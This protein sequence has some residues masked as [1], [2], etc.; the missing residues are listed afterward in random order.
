MHARRCPL[1]HPHTNNCPWPQC[2]CLLPDAL[3]AGT[4]ARGQPSMSASATAP[5]QPA[6][7]AAAAAGCTALL[8]QQAPRNIKGGAAATS[9]WAAR[10]AG[11]RS[12]AA[13][14]N[15]ACC[16]GCSCCCLCAAS[17]AS[18]ELP[19]CCLLLRWRAWCGCWRPCSCCSSLLLLLLLHSATG[20][21]TA[22]WGLP[23][24]AGEAPSSSA[25]ICTGCGRPERAAPCG[26]VAS[27]WL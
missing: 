22:A 23:M 24:V 8:W 27:C 9:C 17:E 6:A 5:A 15:G 14:A 16:H 25:S 11:C 4:A 13:D 12:A 2:R 3:T 19:C 1:A 7:I 20:W 26:P 21:S 18:C 10:A